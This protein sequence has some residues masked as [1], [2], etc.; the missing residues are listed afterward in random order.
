[1]SGQ[2]TAGQQWAALIRDNSSDLSVIGVILAVN[3][4]TR[5]RRANRADVIVACA[6]ILAQNISPANDMAAEVR[7]GIM[8]MIDGFAMQVA[9]QAP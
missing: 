5:A 9:V 8:A 4:E 3:E 6:Q 7:Q 1:M 2:T